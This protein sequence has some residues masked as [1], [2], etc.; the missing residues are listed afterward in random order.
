MTSKTNLR[1]LVGS[2]RRGSTA[3][4]AGRHLPEALR[5]HLKLM[6]SHPGGYSRAQALKLPATMYQ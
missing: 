3:Q 5:F 4:Y 1:K 6:A 2:M